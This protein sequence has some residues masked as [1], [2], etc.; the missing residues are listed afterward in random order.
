LH[1][2][3]GESLMAYKDILRN[4]IRNYEDLEKWLTGQKARVDPRLKD[5]IAKYPGPGARTR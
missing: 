1:E 4:A 2:R 3:K 5:V